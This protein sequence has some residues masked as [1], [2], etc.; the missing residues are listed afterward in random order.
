MLHP[1]VQILLLMLLICLSSLNLRFFRK[2]KI[3]CINSGSKVNR[4]NRMS[5]RKFNADNLFDGYRFRGEGQVLMT[6]E[7]GKISGIVPVQ[8]AGD[9]IEKLEGIL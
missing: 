4:L 5:Y 9:G 3:L 2:R 6:D 1:V 7:N 8:E